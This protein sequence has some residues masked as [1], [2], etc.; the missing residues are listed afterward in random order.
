MD[1]KGVIKR[2]DINYIIKREVKAPFVPKLK[3]ETDVTYFDPE[4]TETP[5]Y[6]VES[7]N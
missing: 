1:N 2:Y 5:I 7:D 4:F 3:N 6:S